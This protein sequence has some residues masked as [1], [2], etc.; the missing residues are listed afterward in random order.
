MDSRLRGND[1]KGA[2]MTRKSGNYKKERDCHVG[3]NSGFS[4]LLATT[5][6]LPR[7][8]NHYRFGDD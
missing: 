3:R 4:S 5:F 2:G 8:Q 6:L 7:P 1:I